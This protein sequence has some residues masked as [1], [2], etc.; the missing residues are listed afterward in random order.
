MIDRAEIG[1]R[2]RVLRAYFEGRYWDENEEFALKRELVLK[3]HEIFPEYPFLIDSDWEVCPNMAQNGQ[4]DFIFTDGMGSFAIVKVKWID[5]LST[6]DTASARRTKKRKKVREQ[7]AGYR[8]V[9][10]SR[11]PDAVKV[12]GYYFTNENRNTVVKI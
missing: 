1:H 5:R 12:E 6:G 11:F 9:W 10:A 4:G 2:D 3:S 8:D 7:A